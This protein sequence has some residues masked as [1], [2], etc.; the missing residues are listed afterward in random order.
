MLAHISD[1]AMDVDVHSSSE[2]F[3]SQLVQQDTMALDTAMSRKSCRKTTPLDVSGVRHCVRV[4]RYLGFKSPSLAEKNKKNS[5]VK[6]RCIPEV[7][8]QL[9]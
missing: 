6:P 5:H 8:I 9:T 4:T 2:L 1:Q 7:F 3:F